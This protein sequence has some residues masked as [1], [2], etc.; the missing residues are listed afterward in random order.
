MAPTFLF[1]I[2]ALLLEGVQSGALR[3]V[4]A[5]ITDPATGR[6]VAHLQQTGAAR[7]LAVS[8]GLLRRRLW[9]PDLDVSDSGRPARP[10]GALRWPGPRQPPLPMTGSAGAAF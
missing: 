4:G 5:L 9:L 2:P 1:E 3:Q 7:D 6:I 8:G 10:A